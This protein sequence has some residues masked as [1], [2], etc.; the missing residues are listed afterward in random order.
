[1]RS[2]RSRRPV[3]ADDSGF[4]LVEVIVAL[5]LLAIVMS[6]ASMLFIRSLAQDKQQQQRQAASQLADQGIELVRAHDPKTILNGRTQA[7]IDAQW[8]SPGPI[9]LSQS[10]KPTAVGSGTAIV[11][12]TPTTV[13]V[14]GTKYS[15]NTIIGICYA[16]RPGASSN[17]VGY[18]QRPASSTGSLSASPGTRQTAM[19][20]AAGRVVSRR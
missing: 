15:V 6:A 11:P 7:Q 8:G 19:D 18:R 17:C 5:G 20:A 9:N 12:A 10:T 4:S 13:V 3:Q 1:M 14:A 2:W 16:G